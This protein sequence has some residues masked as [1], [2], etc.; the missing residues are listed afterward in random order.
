M[1]A[2]GMVLALMAL[3]GLATNVW[4]IDF[5]GAK[6]DAPPRGWAMKGT[7]LGVPDTLFRVVD[8]DGERVL[9]MTAVKGCGG[10]LREIKGVNLART[11]VMRWR[12]RVRQFPP[13]GDGRIPDKADQPLHLYVISGSLLA[14]RCV[15]YTWE[16]DTPRGASE[17]FSLYMGAF[18]DRWWCLR[19]KQ[20]GTN[21]WITEAR[22]VAADFTHQYGKVPESVALMIFCKADMT[23]TRAEAELAWIEFAEAPPQTEEREQPAA[24]SE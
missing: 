4:R 5:S 11:P 6:L 13:G 23:R 22:N 2:L 1:S 12:W 10:L 17:H 7:R 24:D 20:D 14:Q 9:R 19:N 3:P 15:S 18:E 21:V 8:S 16:T